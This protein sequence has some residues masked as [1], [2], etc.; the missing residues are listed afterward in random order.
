M[1]EKKYNNKEI[2]FIF[3]HEL[4]HYKRKDNKCKFR[5]NKD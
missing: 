1:P 3:K 2:R 4:I 5:K